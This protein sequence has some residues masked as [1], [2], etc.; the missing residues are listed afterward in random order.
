MCPRAGAAGVWVAEEED[1]EHQ[2]LH[3]PSPWLCWGAQRSWS[4]GHCLG[5]E[6]L[7]K[8]P[9]AQGNGGQSP[10]ATLS[11]SQHKKHKKGR[12]E[13]MRRERRINPVLHKPSPSYHKIL[14]MVAFPQQEGAEPA[15]LPSSP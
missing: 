2:L 14:G 9:A 1:D 12:T 6:G 7:T 3:T 4:Q 10:L 8:A 15:S 13:R 5:A 11:S